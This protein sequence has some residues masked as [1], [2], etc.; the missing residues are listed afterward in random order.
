MPDENS[1][2]KIKV[3]NTIV[4]TGREI[5]NIFLNIIAPEISFE[6]KSN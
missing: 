5:K 2:E 1:G 3:K 6:I 4:K